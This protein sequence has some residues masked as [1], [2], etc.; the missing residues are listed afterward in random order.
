MTITDVLN[1]WSEMGI[2]S[3]VIPF[4]LIFAIVYAILDKTKDIAE[5][6]TLDIVLENDEPQLPAQNANEL[7]LLQGRQIASC[8]LTFKAR[9]HDGK[10][11]LK[12]VYK[13]NQGN[14]QKQEVILNRSA[15]LIDEQLE[16]NPALS[17]INA[18]DHD[19]YEFAINR[20]VQLED[21]ASQQL[22]A[23]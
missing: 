20:I 18:N 19:W 23:K 2:F 12:V 10:A 4:L 11:V 3:Y 22:A 21:Q 7:M 15:I 8:R 17:Q 5:K 14:I 6:K 16:D 1:V 9:F 13:N